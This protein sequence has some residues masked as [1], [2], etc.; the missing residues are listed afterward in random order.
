[1]SLTPRPLS[2]GRSEGEPERKSARLARVSEW[3]QHRLGAQVATLVA[4]WALAVGCGGGGSNV[5]S[6]W[7]GYDDASYRAATAPG[8]KPLRFGSAELTQPAALDRA[9]PDLGRV[10]VELMQALTASSAPGSDA[11]MMRFESLDVTVFGDRAGAPPLALVRTPCVPAGSGAV[12]TGFTAAATITVNGV[13]ARQSLRETV[14][15]LVVLVQRAAGGCV[16]VVS[17][18]EPPERRADFERFLGTMR[19]ER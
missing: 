6:G 13:Q 18:A 2:P 12:A 9:V 5:P 3:S 19:F 10:A 8:W 16:D 4:A 17:F 11:G 15:R 7:T 14:T 1:V